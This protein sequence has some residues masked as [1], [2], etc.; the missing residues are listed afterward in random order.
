MQTAL[1]KI[2]L[3]PDGWSSANN[4]PIL[5][6]TVHFIS[7]DNV[8]QHLTIGMPELY[9][10]H[11][12]ENMAETLLK[13][14]DEYGIYD[15]IGYIM[16][17]N[18]SSN[19]TMIRALE[20]SLQQLGIPFNQSRRLRCNSHIINLSVLAFLFKKHPWQQ[21]N[22]YIGPSD[23]EL[24]QWRKIGPLGKLHNIIMYVQRSPQRLQAFKALSR[25]FN[26]HR[27]NQTR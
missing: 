27:D 5:G 2:H 17:D 6:V 25:G 19:D 9:G 16:A 7:T 8:L 24:T 23:T 12:S 15:K 14:L 3:S 21:E 26:L 4:L 11:S 1:T 13:L 18:A 20:S 22:D 10:E